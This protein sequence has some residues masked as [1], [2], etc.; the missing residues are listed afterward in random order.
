MNLLVVFIWLLIANVSYGEESPQLQALKQQYKRPDF[1][2]FPADN[3]YS[4]D[5]AQLGKM[6]FF[7]QRLSRHFNMTCATCHNPSLGWEDGVATA[8][9]DINESL[10]RHSPTLLNLAWGETFFWDGRAATLEEQIRGPVEAEVEMNMS[11]AEVVQRLNKVAGYREQFQ[12]VFGE[13]INET[14]I[15]KAIATYERTLV[16][17]TAPFDRWVDGDEGAISAQAKAG[18]ELFNGKAGCSGCHTGWNFTDNQFHDIGLAT[19]DLGRANITADPDHI[20][21]FKTPGLRNIGQ[22]MPYMHN[23]LSANMDAV[24]AHYISG[25]IPRTS[26]S[27]LMKPVLLNQQELDQLKAFMATLDGE[28]KP[29]SLP[30][31]PI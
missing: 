9:G 8:V 18:F 22:R 10:A 28:D 26:R 3:P 19:D 17:G 29:V 14:N 31:L 27:A 16:S 30:I 15:L 1:I 4:A 21:A 11:L 23:G 20:H 7:D 25:G 13:S 6:L 2:P 5:K 12:K 24:L